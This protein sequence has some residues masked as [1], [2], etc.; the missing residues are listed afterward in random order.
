MKDI[1]EKNIMFV[2]LQ[3]FADFK[4]TCKWFTLQFID[5]IPHFHAHN[6]ADKDNLNF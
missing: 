6:S 5:S 3:K 4:N 2:P 1:P